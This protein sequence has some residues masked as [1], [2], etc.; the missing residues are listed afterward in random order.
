MLKE[1]ISKLQNM[2]RV[3][4]V[5]LERFND[6]LATTIAWTPAK[7]GGTNFKT[8]KLIETSNNR[9]EFKASIGGM[10]FYM[11][12]ALIGFGVTVAAVYQEY[13]S[14]FSLNSEHLIML[15]VGVIFLSVGLSLLYFGTKPIVFDNF[16]GL[17]WK[18]RKA[19]NRDIEYTNPE[20]F[21]KLCD[22]HALQIIAEYVRSNKNSYYSYEL[23]LVMDNGNR[24]NVIDHGNIS[25]IRADAS[26][27]AQF[28]NVP[29]WDLTD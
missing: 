16:L 27:L 28:L 29:V 6:P 2:S 17:Y 8:H 20:L 15:L 7:G 3:V 18:G 9:L 19:P 1:L 26:K 25:S 14:N 5:N 10:L 23:N 13:E 24:Q 11:L 21:T 12:F 4:P 22:I